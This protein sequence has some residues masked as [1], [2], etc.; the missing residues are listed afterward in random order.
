MLLYYKRW[1]L[2]CHACSACRPDCTNSNTTYGRSCND[3]TRPYLI[4]CRGGTIQHLQLS[5]ISKKTLIGAYTN[6]GENVDLNPVQHQELYVTGDS[7]QINLKVCDNKRGRQSGARCYECTEFH[8][9]LAMGGENSRREFAALYSQIAAVRREVMT[10][11]K[12]LWRE[13]QRDQQTAL[14]Y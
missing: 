4:M 10:E 6:A 8:T 7:S 14:Q 9:K 13:H 5:A 11:L 3:D 12:R 1:N 2:M